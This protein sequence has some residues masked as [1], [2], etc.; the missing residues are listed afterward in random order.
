M[1]DNSNMTP[2]VKNLIQVNTL[3]STSSCKSKP[4]LPPKTKR[5]KKKARQVSEVWDH[6]TKNEEDPIDPRVVCNY[7]DKDYT[8]DTRR[9][10]TSTLWNHLNN[11]CK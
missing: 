11:Q 9:N 6:F 5:E 2:S 7:Y 10:G 3:D 8:S 4:S 1:E